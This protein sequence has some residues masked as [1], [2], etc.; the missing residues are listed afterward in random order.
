MRFGWLW[1]CTGGPTQT[2]CTMLGKYAY[3][4]MP[5]GYAPAHPR[6]QEFSPGWT[7]IARACPMG[8]HRRTCG[9]LSPTLTARPHEPG[10]SAAGAQGT[11][12]REVNVLTD[13]VPRARS[14]KLPAP[15]RNAG[16]RAGGRVTPPPP[17]HEHRTR[18]QRGPRPTTA[19]RR[20]RSTKLEITRRGS[21]GRSPVAWGS[22][23]RAPRANSDP[24]LGRLSE[25]SGCGAQ[26][27]IQGAK[28]S[29][30]KGAGDGNRT[31]AVSLGS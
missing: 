26:R 17:L 22:G 30:R 21:R 15:L 29:R 24:L 12:A 31:R 25:A 8:A 2:Q 6:A 18:H 3:R 13:K 20:F 19:S 11:Y 5:Q 16:S 23:G 7:R 10:A 27:S 28:E 1:H 14:G 9:Y 4:H